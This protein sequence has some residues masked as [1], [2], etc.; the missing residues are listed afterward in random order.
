MYYREVLDSGLPIKM[1]YREVLDS[2]LPIKM[3]G[4]GAGIE[5]E[6]AT[7]HDPDIKVRI[8]VITYKL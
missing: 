4:I 3:Y 2:G 1:Y 5:N 6:W 8:V 7:S